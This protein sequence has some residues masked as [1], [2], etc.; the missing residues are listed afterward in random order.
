MS[1]TAS[2]TAPL[3]VAEYGE[4]ARDVLEA[5]VWDFIAGGAGA[6]RTL[7]ANEA[8]FAR[9]EVWPRVLTGAGPPDPRTQILGRTWAAPIGI[10][11]VA[12]HTMAHPDGEVATAQAAAAAGVP[13]VVS[14]FAGRTF[15][16]IAI[17]PGSRWLQIYCFRDLSVTRRLIERAEE[18]GFEALVLTV[19]AP[20][21]GR[22]LRD[23]R[24]GFRLPPG[25]APA[26]LPGGEYG[27]P[28]EHAVAEF[29]AGLDWSIVSWLQS[30]SALPVLVKGILTAADARRAVAEGVD[31]IVVSNHGGRQLDGAPA[32]LH[33]LPRVVAAVAGACPV[34][35]DGGVRRGEDV[36]VSLACGAAGVL[37]GRPVLHGLAVDGRRG[38]ERV[39]GIVIEEM[40]DAMVLAGVGS[41][42]DAGPDLVEVIK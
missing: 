34:L 42:A 28:G 3:T 22:R 32:S 23:L 20:R 17:E 33:A 37:L 31:G 15:A 29:D 12:Y 27:S 35:L 11:P 25:I 39:L 8:A 26:N 30:V 21:L 10:A 40:L 19:D 13:F 9:A 24:S 41:P 2:T 7:A 14:T 1:R 6:E 5:G 36:L 16:E 18:S 38:V 4:L